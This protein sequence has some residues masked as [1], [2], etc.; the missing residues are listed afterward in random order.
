MEQNNQQFKCTGDCFRCQPLQRQYCAAQWS[1][2]GLRI[3]EKIESTL[4][5]MNGTIKELSVKIDAIQGN[6]AS[7]FDPTESSV[8]GG[9]AVETSPIAQEGSG[10]TE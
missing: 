5:S 1:Y 4:E 7:L 2:N 10:A 8:L 6:E 3:M 9:S